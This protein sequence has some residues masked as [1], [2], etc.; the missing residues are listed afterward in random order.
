MVVESDVTPMTGNTGDGNPLTE[1]LKQR[2][3]VGW[4]GFGKA[5]KY[6]L[7]DFDW[8]VVDW[9]RKTGCG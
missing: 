9:V 8:E 4:A 7:K 3:V 1:Y 6:P 2:I 5:G